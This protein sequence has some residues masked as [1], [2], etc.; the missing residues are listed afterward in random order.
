M[1]R[2]PFSFMIHNKCTFPSKAIKKLLSAVSLVS[3]KLKLLEEGCHKYNSREN[4]GRKEKRGKKT[5]TFS[6]KLINFYSPKGWAVVELVCVLNLKMV[7]FYFNRKSFISIDNLF[8]ASIS[9]ALYSL[10]IIWCWFLWA[11]LP[12][13][14][15]QQLLNFRHKISNS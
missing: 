4:R 8:C 10:D 14:Y 2:A 13:N 12:L 3:C 11:F 7:S 5:A 9:S 6:I 1:E 15:E